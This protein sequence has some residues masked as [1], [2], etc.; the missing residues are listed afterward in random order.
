[1]TEDLV[2]DFKGVEDSRVDQV[3]S[4]NRYTPRIAVIDYGMGNLHSV[5]KGLQRAGADAYT[6]DTP[7]TLGAPD[8][9]VLPGVGN[10]G[11][12][13]CNLRRAGFDSVVS[14]WIEEDRFFLGICLG[15][16]LLYAYSEEAE[17]P[18]LGIVDAPVLRLPKTVR[19][20]HMGW[21][22]VR[23]KVSPRIAAGSASES[24]TTSSNSLGLAVSRDTD[25]TQTSE[26]VYSLNTANGKYFYFVHSYAAPVAPAGSEVV[27][28]TDYGTEFVAGFQRGRAWATQFHPE[29]SG[30]A[31][32]A[33]LESF[34]AAS[35]ASGVNSGKK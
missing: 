4:E 31:G 30:T 16:Q 23:A 35:A 1:M 33:L 24:S 8:S 27:L 25:V 20:P 15:L 13:V 29:K 12:C 6:V 9:L 7:D 32:L 21:N 28:V 5:V 18:G 19:V 34:V 26:G 22:T 14:Q 3:G 11:K 2:A 10:F 17:E